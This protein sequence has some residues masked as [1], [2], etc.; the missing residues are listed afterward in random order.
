MEN[1][2]LKGEAKAWMGLGICEE[3]VS[4]IF[5]AMS[6]LVTALSKAE[7]GNVQKLEKEINSMQS[8]NRHLAQER[9]QVPQDDEGADE[10]K[11]YGAVDT[12]NQ[13]AVGKLDGIL[14]NMTT[15][16]GKFKTFHA[17]IDRTAFDKMI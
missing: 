6:N 13:K 12:L 5:H 10:E 3:K 11:L 15:A 7:D 4:N 14:T 16:K 17:K 9:N 2:N 1:K 8:Q